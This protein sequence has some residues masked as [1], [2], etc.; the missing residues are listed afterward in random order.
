MY[1]M[2]SC[3]EWSTLPSPQP[4]QI[5]WNTNALTR[6]R[7][8]TLR[9][10]RTLKFWVKTQRTFVL[11]LT[12]TDKLE[13]NLRFEHKWQNNKRMYFTFFFED[14]KEIWKQCTVDKKMYGFTKNRGPTEQKNELSFSNL[15]IEIGI[16][17]RPLIGR[18]A[19][20]WE[21][22]A[23]CTWRMC[24]PGAVQVLWAAEGRAALIYTWCDVTGH[25]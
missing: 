24:P 20:Q 22:N 14:L 3:M 9:T 15:S 10:K 8:Q 13:R 7:E 5:L 19:S 16:S 4:E 11:P 6:N 12:L 2:E 23:P 21:A 18:Y 17:N 25:G 1:S